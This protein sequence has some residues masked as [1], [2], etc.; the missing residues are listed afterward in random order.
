[1]NISQTFTSVDN[2]AELLSAVDKM[3][4]NGFK[5]TQIL[6]TRKENLD[7]IYSFEREYELINIHLVIDP[8]TEIESIS[9]IYPCAYLY[10]NEMK[11][12]FG[13]KINKINLDF[14]GRFYKTAV[15]TPYAEESGENSGKDNS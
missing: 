14:G 11:D 9:G 3:K 15:K 12:L 5:L 1:M 7:L 4:K 10:E 13:V 8:D 6:A 2:D